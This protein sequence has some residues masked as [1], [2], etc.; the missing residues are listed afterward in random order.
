[1]KFTYNPRIIR[2][3]GTEL[4]TSDSIALSELIKNSFDA[5]ANRVDIRFLDSID[6]LNRSTLINPLPAIVEQAIKETGSNF[7]II[8]DNG[9]G[10]DKV[11]LQKGFFEVGS[12][13]K[14]TDKHNASNEEVILGNKGIGRLSAQRLSPILFVETASYNEKNE[15]ESNFVRIIWNDFISNKNADAKEWQLSLQKKQSYTRLW[16][17]G[18]EKNPIDFKKFISTI[19]EQAKDL[20]GS[21]YGEKQEYLRIE[22]ELLSTLNFLYSPFEI[23]ERPADLLLSYN[24]KPVRVEFNKDNLAIAEAMHSFSIKDNKSLTLKLTIQP[25]FIQRIHFGQIGDKLFQDYKKEAVF[26]K[27]LQKKHKTRYET[28]LNDEISLE[29]YF[30]WQLKSNKKELTEEAIKEKI[31]TSIEL[32]Q[33]ISPLEGCIYSFK[34]ERK[35]LEMAYQSA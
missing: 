16:L 8:E 33:A 27:A 7:I 14:E 28:S 11:R 13:I 12:D 6:N 34:R 5:K 35:M 32:L 4:I 3:L 17:V 19:S 20:F 31:K 18:D 29:K 21:P 1:M 26:Y 10:M 24:E 23:K 25:W 22:E 15:F 9:N 2:Q 30:E